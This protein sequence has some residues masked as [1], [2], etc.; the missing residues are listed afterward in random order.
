MVLTNIS[1]EKFQLV[2]NYYVKLASVLGKSEMTARRIWGENKDI[3]LSAR[4]VV[5][6]IVKETGLTEEEVL[7]KVTA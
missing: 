2:D 6:L 1:R 7:E 4:K 5:D 3:R